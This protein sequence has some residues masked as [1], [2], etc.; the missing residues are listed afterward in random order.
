MIPELIAIGR[1]CK[2]PV[3]LLG[4]ILFMPFHDVVHDGALA[5]LRARS[6]QAGSYSCRKCAVIGRSNWNCLV[7]QSSSDPH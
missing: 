3:K 7:T 5:Q 1:G 4:E 2:L 6:P